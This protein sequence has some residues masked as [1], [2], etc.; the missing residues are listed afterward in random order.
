MG[1]VDLTSH[2]PI[3]LE[4]LNASLDEPCLVTSYHRR[5]PDTLLVEP[6]GEASFG[7]ALADGLGVPEQ[8][9]LPERLTCR[10]IRPYAS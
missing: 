8:Q 1:V 5:Y 4:A 7:V 2:H 3:Q 9:P 10:P 6:R